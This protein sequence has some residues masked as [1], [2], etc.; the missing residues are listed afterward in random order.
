VDSKIARL[1]AS[2]SAELCWRNN[3]AHHDNRYC[4]WN[5]AGLATRTATPL[6]SS[7]PRTFAHLAH[8]AAAIF[9]RAAAD[10]VR[11]IR[12][13]PV[14]ALA[15]CDPVRVFAHRRFCAMLIRRRASADNA[16]RGSQLQP[17]KSFR[18]STRISPPKMLMIGGWPCE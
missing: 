7:P 17:S 1:A 11:F 3:T 9:L 4:T 8:C 2:F 5:K 15:G 14:T 12:A 13:D 16:E 18:C 6:S 10:I